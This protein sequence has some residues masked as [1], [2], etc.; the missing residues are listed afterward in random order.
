MII[1]NN[2]HL[3]CNSSKYNHIKNSKDGNIY[4]Q[5]LLVYQTKIKNNRLTKAYKLLTHKVIQLMLY[6]TV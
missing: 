1:E 5:T 2:K 3:T 6:S 4:R